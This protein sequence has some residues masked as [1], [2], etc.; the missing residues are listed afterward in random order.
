RLGNRV[1]KRVKEAAA[2]YTTAM[3]TTS[4]RTAVPYRREPFNTPQTTLRVLIADKF[5]QSGIDGVNNLGCE[6]TVNPDLA[7][8]TLPAAVVQS[9]GEVLIVRST[10]VPAT[11]FDKAKKLSMVL[12][13]GAGYDNIDVAAA[14]AKGIFVT[15]C[16]GKNAVAVAELAWA[17]I[18]SCD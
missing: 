5:E 17:L 2:R 16:P 10:K 7:P 3:T 18:L 1:A 14:S 15:N 12:R 9:D 6:V 13:A 11:V 8:E 4:A